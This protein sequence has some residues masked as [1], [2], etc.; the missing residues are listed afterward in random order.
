ML[1]IVFKSN[2]KSQNLN[3]LDKSVL[4][5]IQLINSLPYLSHNKKAEENL[6]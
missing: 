3:N 1:H 4:I 5:M 2:L 6:S